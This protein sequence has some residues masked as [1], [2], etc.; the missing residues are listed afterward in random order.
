ML[1]IGTVLSLAQRLELHGSG[2]TVIVTHSSSFEL[3]QTRS[4]A[5][6]LAKARRELR[7]LMGIG[8]A[9]VCSFTTGSLPG[10]LS[11]PKLGEHRLPIIMRVTLQTH[12]D[13]LSDLGS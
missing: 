3:K 11:R 1:A 5:Q 13:G 9:P 2:R 10:Q 8:I 7:A 4:F 6:T 12:E